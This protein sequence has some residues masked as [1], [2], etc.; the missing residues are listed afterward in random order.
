MKCLNCKK[1]CF[2]KDRPKGLC[3][4]CGTRFVFE[5]AGFNKDPLTDRL[6]Q[7]AIDKVSCA[8]T[9]RWGVENLYYEVCRRKR[10]SLA[11]LFGA[12]VLL[13][14][15]S[16]FL[17]GVAY[18][19]INDPTE[20]E[21]PGAANTSPLFWVVLTLYFSLVLWMTVREYL[22]RRYPVFT[23]EDFRDYYERWEAIRGAPQGVIVRRTTPPE[24]RTVESDVAD[25]SFDRAVICDRAR[26]ADLLIANDFHFENNCAILA[27]DGYPAGLFETIRGMLRRNPKLKV[28]ALH[29]ASVEGCQLAQRLATDPEWFGGGV[30]VID[31]GLRPSQAR[32]LFGNWQ[33]G[34]KGKVKACDAISPR[35]A[36]W[37]GKYRS[38]IAAITPDQLIKRLFRAMSQDID[39]S[40]SDVRVIYLSDRWLPAKSRRADDGY[41]GSSGDFVV[42]DSGHSFSNEASDMD[43]LSD[44]FG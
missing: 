18:A 29:D 33:R 14:F 43:G 4:H 21:H 6:F 36:K 27:V 24:P 9:V 8:G 20:L 19:F 10:T 44:S 15:V 39:T 13:I 17:A 12:L 38:E 34:S 3:P 30:P 7:N 25:Y 42:I 11:K 26:T 5:P 16:L 28:Y 41:E 2:L 31:V 35:E 1:D 22:Q 37:L 40:R 23:P 32:R